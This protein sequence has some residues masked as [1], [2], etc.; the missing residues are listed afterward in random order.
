MAEIEQMQT[1]LSDW[2]GIDYKPQMTRGMEPDWKLG[3]RGQVRIAFMG[4][5]IHHHAQA[6]GMAE[7]R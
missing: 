3:G 4:M 5:M 6:I 2:Y 1:W 7:D